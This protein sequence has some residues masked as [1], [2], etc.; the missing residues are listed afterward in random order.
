LTKTL[1]SL[2]SNSSNEA[3]LVKY[4]DSFMTRI[5]EFDNNEKLQFT[6]S[7]VKLAEQILNMLG[8]STKI[9]KN[10]AKPNFDTALCVTV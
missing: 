4:Y 5:N 10:Y 7:I 8:E 6:E 3:Q 9:N 2:T 1:T